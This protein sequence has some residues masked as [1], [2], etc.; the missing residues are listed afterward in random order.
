MAELKR[1]FDTDL[2]ELTREN[3]ERARSVLAKGQ[4]QDWWIDEETGHKSP[5]VAINQVEW[6][7]AYC[8][9]HAIGLLQAE[10]DELTVQRDAVL[11][12]HEEVD[13]PDGFCR[14]D[15]DAWPCE[16]VRAL[17]PSRVVKP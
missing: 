3:Y 1:E 11:A 15:N 5:C 2:H 12:L 14:H 16:T 8:D 7:F 6:L 17:D 4:A 10:V 13:G 9:S